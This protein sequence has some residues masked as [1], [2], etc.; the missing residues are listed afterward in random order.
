MHVTAHL[1]VD[2]IAIDQD[3]DVTCLVE[4]TAPVSD[5]TAT[6]PGQ[7][8]VVVLDRSGS[9]AG[10][11]LESAKE[12]I[13]GLVRR[14]A[15]QDSFGLV[16]FD[17]HA[18]V[19]IPV[20]RMGE[21]D[22]PTLETLIRRISDGGSTDLSAGYLLGLRELKRAMTPT[23][24]DAPAGATLLLVS[25]GEA[26]AGITDPVQMRDVAAGGNREHRITT[27]TLGIGEGYDEVLLEA[28]TR[29]GNGTHAFAPDVD[30]AIREI[31]QVVTDLL[32]KS[33]VAAMMRI[34][35]NAEVS[36]V[37]VRQDLPHWV[38]GDA[39]VVNLGDLFAGETR[40]TL[41]TL[42]VPAIATLGTATVAEVTF[43]Y[44]SLPDLKEH[45]VVLPIAVNVVPGDEARDRVTNPVVEVEE[46]L[47][48]IDDRKKAMAADLRSGDA[49]SAQRTLA[50]AMQVLN[51]KREEVKARTNDASLRE[52]LDDAA[53]DLLRLADDVRDENIAFAGKAVMNS[54]AATSRGRNIRGQAP[55]S[56]GH[57]DDDVD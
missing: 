26:N 57:N 31:S 32:D 48:E 53:R 17:D 21:H 54:Y 28:I 39:I 46:L 1:N 18:D 10:E 44:A 55:S 5:A 33:V 34:R 8:L 15:P 6:R 30:S 38:D 37:M 9:M 12:A 13:A 52:R 47:R 3:E 56:K 43:E 51:D 4:L 35:P 19:T 23:S 16:V 14:L 25:D 11:R 2:L 20:R 40:K 49:R 27:S 7:A 50:G 45:R 29:G 24:G 42:R 36:T 22:V 41:F